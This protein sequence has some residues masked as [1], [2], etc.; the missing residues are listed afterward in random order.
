MGIAGIMPLLAVVRQR[1]VTVAV[2][3]RCIDLLPDFTRMTTTTA[4]Q[5]LLVRHD[6]LRCDIDTSAP[7]NGKGRS[8]NDRFINSSLT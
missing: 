5:R 6:V 1:A 8:R 4:Q 2:R 7:E 3:Q